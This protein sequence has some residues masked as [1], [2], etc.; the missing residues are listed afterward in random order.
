MDTS[1][2]GSCHCQAIA[3]HFEGARPI[4]EMNLR[5]CS[6]GFCTRHRAR[7]ASDPAGR[8]TIVET[9]AD[10]I[11]RYR[12]GTRTADFLLCRHCGC[13]LAAVCTVEGRQLAVF[14]VN[15]FEVDDDLEVAPQTMSFSG[16]S[17]DDRLA[18]RAAS[19]TPVEIRSST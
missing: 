19:W 11:H 14:N 7:Y 4:S 10:T 18:R 6:C 9:R 13:Y 12:F 5:Q 16:E 1:A 2:K 17:V 8:L 3:I 15:N